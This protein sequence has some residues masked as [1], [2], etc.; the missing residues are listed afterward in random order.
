M[1]GLTLNV[2]LPRVED[3]I[4]NTIGLG[5]IF[6]AAGAGG[7]LLFVL[8]SFVGLPDARRDAWGRRGMVGGFVVGTL[9]YMVALVAQLL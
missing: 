4:P 9:L 2:F 5:A 7:I 1:P 8:A 3:P 6:S